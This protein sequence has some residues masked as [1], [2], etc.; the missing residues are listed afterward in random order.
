[1]PQS[2]VLRRVTHFDRLAAVLYAYEQFQNLQTI[3]FMVELIGIST[4]VIMICTLI[5]IRIE[6]PTPS[7][8]YIFDLI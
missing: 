8:I 3:Y 5:E 6:I 4:V 2:Y 7:N 1:M